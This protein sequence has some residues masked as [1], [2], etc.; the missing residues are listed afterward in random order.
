MS[1][2]HDTLFRLTRSGDFEKAHQWLDEQ[3]QGDSSS[4][5]RNMVAH[6][7]THVLYSQKRLEDAINYIQKNRDDFLCKTSA[8]AE[9]AELMDL[10]GRNAEAQAELEKA[11]FEAEAERYPVLVAD[12]RFMLLLIK[13]RGGYRPSD[14]ELD[15]FPD[16]FGTVILPGRPFMKS[17]LLKLINGE[18]YNA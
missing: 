17:D 5:T 13:V 2:D 8:Y 4:E 1:F 7:R 10:L 18:S 11:P 15:M 16:H 12:A 14:I 3:S 6:G 9:V